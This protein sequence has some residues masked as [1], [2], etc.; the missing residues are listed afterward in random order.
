MAYKNSVITCPLQVMRMSTITETIWPTPLAHSWRNKQIQTN[1]VFRFY[2]SLTVGNK[3][4]KFKNKISSR[5]LK[6][7]AKS[8]KPYGYVV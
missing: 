3:G 4:K 8:K 1:L 6:R 5:Q 7:E 2:C